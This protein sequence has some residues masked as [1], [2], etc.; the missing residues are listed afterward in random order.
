LGSGLEVDEEVEG[1]RGGGVED[2]VLGAGLREGGGGVEALKGG[3]DG[4]DVEGLE[5]AGGCQ[6]AGF[7]A[8]LF[9]WLVC[10]QLF[11]MRH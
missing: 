2:A 10:V 3:E 4:V 11:G 5:S 8:D 1:L 7:V 6:G 9:E